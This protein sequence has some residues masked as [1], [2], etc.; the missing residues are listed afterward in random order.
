MKP[1]R[2]S[3]R[4][5]P[6]VLQAQLETCHVCSTEEEYVTERDSL[7]EQFANK[8]SGVEFP[9]RIFVIG[10]PEKLDAFYVVTQKLEYK[11]PSFLR[12][13]DVVVKL[14]FVLKHNF[15]E[16]S[17]IL[18]C[19]IARYFYNIDYPRKSKNA[20]LLQ[21]LAFLEQPGEQHQS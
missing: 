8:T 10:K 4:K 20:Q 7:R 6:S 5:L 21:L 2:T 12:C 3:K 15:P 17:E 14:K 11:L 9:P 16:S 1:T 13:M 19:F 18:W